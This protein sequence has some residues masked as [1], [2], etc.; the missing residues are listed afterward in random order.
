MSITM[1]FAILF[2]FGVGC[3]GAF[4]FEVIQN[5]VTRKTLWSELTFD[6]WFLLIGCAMIPVG[7][8][9]MLLTR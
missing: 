5:R 4:G 8:I 1:M 6:Q 7:F 2:G 3:F 9:G